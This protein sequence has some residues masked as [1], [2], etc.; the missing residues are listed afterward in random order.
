MKGKS[1]EKYYRILEAAAI[2]FAQKGF[3]QSTVSQI[4]RQAGVADGTIYLYFK[5]KDD[6][7]VQFFRFKTEQVFK[8]FRERVD[9]AKT[10]AEKLK[11]L[12]RS[13][14]EVFQKDRNM[15]VIYQAETRRVN[16]LLKD[17][18]REMT[19][20]YL[21][22]IAEIVQQGQSQNTFRKDI[23]I[24]LV[25]HYVLGAVEEVISTWILTGGKHD[26]KSMA[27]PL[28]D[29]IIRGIGDPR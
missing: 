8:S 18:I 6:I 13:H 11:S 27:D 20:T 25:K 9:T 28:V 14:L 22:M 23:P 26:L 3:F 1:F 12:I 10:P 15:A 5:N 7:L 2:E 19:K 16:P 24:G 29:L 4:A 17:H 21:D